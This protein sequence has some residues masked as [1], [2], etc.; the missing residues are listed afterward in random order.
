MGFLDDFLVRA[1]D[2]FEDTVSRVAD[3]LEHSADK[4]ESASKTADDRLHEVATAVDTKSEQLMR[5]PRT[6][7][8]IVRRTQP[9]FKTRSQPRQ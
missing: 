8:G 1:I 2:Q 9:V 5:S 6:I 4:V 3:T 7:D